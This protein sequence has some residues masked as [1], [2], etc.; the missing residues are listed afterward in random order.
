MNNI[1][2]VGVS[3]RRRIEREVVIVSKMFICVIFVCQEE[4]KKIGVGEIVRVI[5]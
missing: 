5:I 2:S 3:G 1:S 4:R